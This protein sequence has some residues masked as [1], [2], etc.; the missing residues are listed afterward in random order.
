MSSSSSPMPYPTHQPRRSPIAAR[1]YRVNVAGPDVFH[2][3]AAGSKA[4]HARSPFCRPTDLRGTLRRRWD[5]GR[6]TGVSGWLPD[7]E[8]GILCG[9]SGEAWAGLTLNPTGAH[10]SG[11]RTAG[12]NVAPQRRLAIVKFSAT[13]RGPL[14]GLVRFFPPGQNT[15][16]EV[17]GWPRARTSGKPVGPGPA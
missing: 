8:D 11:P 7:D 12:V 2:A 14:P 6:R 4:H 1:H 13:G 10:S 5:R 3:P 16:S 15:I 9:R 17:T